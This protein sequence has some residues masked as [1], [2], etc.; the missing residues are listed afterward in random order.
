MSLRY[1]HA[2][3]TVHSPLMTSSRIA[4]QQTD[5]VRSILFLQAFRVVRLTVWSKCMR[6]CNSVCLFL[7]CDI[8]CAR[9]SIVSAG[10]SGHCN[11]AALA[12]ALELPPV[13]VVQPCE[14]CAI[15]HSIACSVL[16][17]LVTALEVAMVCSDSV[18]RLPSQQCEADTSS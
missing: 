17:G 18:C 6:S 2:A 11:L 1:C 8:S 12:Y 15:V 7:S 5:T 3:V 16:C 10:I 4:G 9:S 13:Q 14:R